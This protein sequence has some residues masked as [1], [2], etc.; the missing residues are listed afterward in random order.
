MSFCLQKKPFTFRLSRKLNTS[1]GFIEKKRGWLIYLKGSTGNIGWGEVSPMQLSE[2]KLCEEVL[3]E[4]S[5][6]PSRQELED[7]IINWPQAMSFGIGAAL[8]EYDEIIGCKTNEGWLKGPPSARLLTQTKNSLLEEVDC[9]V[10]HFARSN[11][12]LTVK[13]K[14]GIKSNSHEKTLLK[15]I[16]ERLPANAHLRLDA[17]G[18]WNRDQAK[19][20][21]PNFLEDPRLEWLEQ[22]LSTKDFEGL[23]ELS[24]QI[25][26]ALDE[27]LVANPSLREHWKGWQVRR[28]VL[29][30]DP[31][32]ILHELKKGVGYRVLST[33]FETG[34]GK[35]WLN[36][37]AALQQQGPTPTAP[38]LAPGWCPKGPLFSPNPELVWSAV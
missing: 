12:Q 26:I 6:N 7:G 19:K 15:Q 36:H 3:D 33:A 9:L 35:R 20:W 21:I 25:P 38:G 27:S 37:L 8:A 30:G 17:N 14:V 5:A 32:N 29:E 11:Q 34:I 10:K 22:P 1:Q 16:L 13:W 4:L 2:L 28:P 23:L 18:G 31:R 24:E